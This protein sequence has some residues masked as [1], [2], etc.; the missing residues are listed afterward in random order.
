MM[1]HQGKH[2]FPKVYKTLLNKLKNGIDP[3]HPSNIRRSLNV[4]LPTPALPRAALSI[5]K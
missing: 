1:P 3:V 5:I 4:D 2:S